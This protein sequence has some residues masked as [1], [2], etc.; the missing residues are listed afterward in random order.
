MSLYVALR[1]KGIVK[2]ELRELFEPIA[3]EGRWDESPDPVLRDFGEAYPRAGLIPRGACCIIDRWKKEP[4]ERSYNKDTG[5]WIFQADI[6]TRSVPINE[7]FNEIVPYC[8]ESVEH[9]ET[10]YEAWETSEQYTALEKYENGKLKLIG[11]L[12]TDGI[13]VP[14]E[15]KDF[16]NG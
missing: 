10:W 6:N 1:F 13:F 3:L 14:G 12:D 8:M 2:Q 5:E 4:W 11:W 9:I 7:F 15:N 16:R